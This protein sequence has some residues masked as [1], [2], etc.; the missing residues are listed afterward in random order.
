MF[1][2]SDG[3]IPRQARTLSNRSRRSQNAGCERARRRP[4]PSAGEREMGDTDDADEFV[5]DGGADARLDF[6]AEGDDLVRHHPGI[7]LCGRPQ[8]VDVGV[9][10]HDGGD[11]GR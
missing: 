1:S 6:L 4:E 10:S 11:E 7:L 2:T 8:V 3:E 5:S 9:G